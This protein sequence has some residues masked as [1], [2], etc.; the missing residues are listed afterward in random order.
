MRFESAVTSVSWIP[1]AA[2]TGVTKAPFELGVTHYDDPPPDSLR[3]LESVVGPDGARF[4]N[5]LRAWI[6]VEDGRIVDYG[7]LGK[8]WISTSKVQLGKLVV[9]VPA[10][11]FP[12]LRAEPEVGDGFVR[13]G[14]TA[15]GRPGLPSPRLV[16]EAP[17]FKIR[18]PSVWTTLEL[19]I[20]ADGTSTSELVGATT[21]PRHWLYDERGALT[22]K[23]AVIDFDEWY[24]HAYGSHTPWGNEDHA[25]S[26]TAA[27]TALERKLSTIIMRHG[28]TPPKPHKLRH[29]DTPPKPHKLRHGE[30][31]FVEGEIGDDLALVLDGVV[32]VSVGGVSLAAL[33]PGSVIGERAAERSGRRTATITATTDCRIVR[34]RRDLLDEDD[35]L[36]L[37]GVHRREETA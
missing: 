33:G 29:G 37:T 23:S 16:G 26:T 4:A 35:L 32:D 31:L 11:A 2:I 10:V 30:A 24:H 13:F 36:D 27:E 20:R 15:G 8:G 25:V 28:D 12:D 21:F 7:Q 17:Y 5:E 3:D 6:T 9:L 14:Q 1:S 19:T 34:V 22:G 18:G